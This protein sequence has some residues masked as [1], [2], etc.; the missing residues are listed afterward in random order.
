MAEFRI[1]DLSAESGITVRNIRFYQEK[2]LLPPPRK[3]GRVGIYGDAH[4]GR[5]R[6]IGE[7]TERGYTITAIT[8]LLA[9]WESGRDV[10]DILGLEEALTHPWQDEDPR[11]ITIAEL[12]QI[13]GSQLSIADLNRLIGRAM[14]LRLIRVRGLTIEVSSPVLL[15]AFIQLMN[16][17]VDLDRMLDLAGSVAAN[18]ESVGKDFVA[19]IRE[20]VDVGD[21]LPTSA[22]A[23]VITEMINQLRPLAKRAVDAVFATSMERL[24]ADVADE[25]AK[26]RQTTETRPPDCD[27][28]H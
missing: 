23:T 14:E 9:A 1:D 2:G 27:N 28:G 4:L 20:K 5:L 12:R 24:L 6:L 25:L 26:A 3:V 17:G 15:E 10:A 19:L 21:E 18:L 7:L 8:D 16:I 22:Q 13:V 11:Q